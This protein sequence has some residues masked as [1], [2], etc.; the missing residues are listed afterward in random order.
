MKLRYTRTLPCSHDHAHAKETRRKVLVKLNVF[1]WPVISNFE[2]YQPLSSFLN[3]CAADS[4]LPTKIYKPSKLRKTFWPT[5]IP[6]LRRKQLRCK[7]RFQTWHKY[8]CHP[9][10]GC[11]CCSQ[12][13][14]SRKRPRLF[15][16]L[17]Q[18]IFK[19]FSSPHLIPQLS[20]EGLLALCHCRTST[21][22]AKSQRSPPDPNSKLRIRVVPAG[23]QLQAL[24][25]SVPCR[26]LAASPGSAD[27][28]CKR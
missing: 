25:R 6:M 21:A 23:P 19:D 1:R 20:G 10:A 12:A 3:M 26:T 22:N 8:L 11:C 27:L 9:W 24:D 5:L 13:L 4:P 17:L 2:L 28:N 16:F 18:S 14:S 7:C 15:E